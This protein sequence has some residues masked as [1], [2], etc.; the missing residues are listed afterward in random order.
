MK[1]SILSKHNM[2]FKY[3]SS[4]IECLIYNRS[5]D[6]EKIL[7]GQNNIFVMKRLISIKY[8]FH[9]KL[10]NH[11]QKH[12][13]Y[14]VQFYCRWSLYDLQCKR[15]IKR[16][17]KLNHKPQKRSMRISDCE[18]ELGHGWDRAEERAGYDQQVLHFNYV[19]CAV[20]FAACMISHS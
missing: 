12:C 6:L 5:K 9:Q 16:K 7:R 4:V 10:H 11:R 18:T 20:L 14:L 2:L 3:P 13:C 1:K 15:I 17:P 19:P 8:L